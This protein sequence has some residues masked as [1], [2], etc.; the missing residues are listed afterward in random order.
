MLFVRGTI[1]VFTVEVIIYTILGLEN[2]CYK[3]AS[4]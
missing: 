1:T 3:G 4:Q 2:W